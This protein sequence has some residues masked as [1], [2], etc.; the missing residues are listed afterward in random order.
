MTGSRKLVVPAAETHAGKN[1]GLILLPFFGN[2]PDTSSSTRFTDARKAHFI[3]QVY[4]HE[5][6]V[7]TRTPPPI[8]TTTTQPAPNFVFRS[9]IE[10]S[11]KL[12]TPPIDCAASVPYYPGLG[13][14]CVATPFF[15]FAYTIARL[16][17]SEPNPGKTN[18]FP[19]FDFNRRSTALS[20][21]VYG[22]FHKMDRVPLH[23]WN[24]Q[25][26]ALDEMIPSQRSQLS[27]S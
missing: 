8:T 5:S 7:R 10:P 26:S 3:R 17:R 4:A 1:S 14:W 22:S 2:M 25:S 18:L 12:A 15:L 9:S 13:L 23:Q 24:V 20:S 19:R 21:R 11:K 16:S 6:Y 27:R